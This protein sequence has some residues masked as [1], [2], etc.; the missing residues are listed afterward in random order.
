MVA[1]DATV[2]RAER[3]SAELVIRAATTIRPILDEERR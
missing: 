1:V 3:V 2:R